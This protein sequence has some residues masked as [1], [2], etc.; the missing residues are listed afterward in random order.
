[1]RHIKRK[2]LI[3]S[4]VL[5]LFLVFSSVPQA[6]AL[7]GPHTYTDENGSVFLGGDYIE[8]GLSGRGS[9][10]TDN[11]TLPPG[12][13]GTDNDVRIGM[14]TNPTGFGV[15]PDLR[16]DFF[17]P[18]S[19][20]E[21]WVVGYKQ[22]GTPHTGSNSLLRGANG[23]PDNA[24]TDESSGDMLKARSVGT[25]D[26]KLQV[27]QVISFKRGDKFFENKVTLKNIDTSNIDSV[28]Y[29]RSFDPDNTVYQGGDYTTH[30]YI[31]YTHQAGDGKAVVIAD[32]NIGGS[33]PVFAQNGSYSPILFY[34]S[35]ARARVSTYGFSNSDPYAALAYDSAEPK[36]T[37]VTDD[38]A[39]T[40]AFD[41]GTLAPD[42]SETVSYY[43]SL[44]NRDF[45]AV[46]ADIQAASGASSGGVATNIPNNGDANND[47]TQDT[48]QTNIAG[49][50][51]PVTNKYALV[52]ATSGCTV[53]DQSMSA[54]SSL[55]A[56][57]SGYS[58]P[59]GL[60]NFTLQ[61][62]GAPGY[63]TTVT[64]YY[65]GLT[66]SNFVLRK[67][68]PNTKKYATISG[69]TIS[70]V[71][72]DG[73]AVTKVSYQITDGGPLDQDGTANG[74]IVDPAGLALPALVDAGTNVA[75]TTGIAALLAM[76]AVVIRQKNRRYRLVR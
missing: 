4:L 3:S 68:N 39:I 2:P 67:Y 25:F 57:D 22:S 53:H 58:Y 56:Q 70:H 31:P 42:A 75:L 27:T 73:Q 52:E 48:T 54:A 28:R 65:Y 11:E 18:G 32:A 13:Y 74:V 46:L 50:V 34:S 9:F 76:S 10:G 15:A 5:G 26:S 69:A 6:F 51:N 29:M 55:A 21:R 23:I 7:V 40:I 12:F 41:V 60:M 66:G 1:M 45:S 33:D 61:S 16:M 43:T 64:Q 30:N 14:S 44:D 47:G 17:M 37:D 38:Q 20:E 24:V 19:P 71:T 59:A 8:L 49:L 63:T 72:I 35:D 62:C 36:G